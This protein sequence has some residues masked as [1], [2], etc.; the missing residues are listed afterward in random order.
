MATYNRQIET[1]PKQQFRTITGEERTA[2]DDID[3]EGEGR[4]LEGTLGANEVPQLRAR[5][6]YTEEATVSRGKLDRSLL[7]RAED[8]INSFSSDDLVESEINLEALHGI[9]LGLWRSAKNSSHYHQDILS[10]LE[11]AL[12]CKKDFTTEDMALFREA[13]KDLKNEV[14]IEDHVKIISGRFI[15]QGFSPL[16]FLSEMKDGDDKK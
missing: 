12:L 8:I 3:A 11:N 13:V 5:R 15:S 1:I 9:I 4:Q 2:L 16:A 7:N 14:L 6:N 10:T